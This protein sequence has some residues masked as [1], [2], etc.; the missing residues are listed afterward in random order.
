MDVVK[1]R[2]DEAL[3]D[4]LDSSYPSEDDESEVCV[5]FELLNP[6]LYCL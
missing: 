2:G 3:Y 6:A 4:T 1:D 5:G